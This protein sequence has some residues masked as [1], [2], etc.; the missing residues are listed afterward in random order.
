MITGLDIGLDPVFD[1][2]F[3]GQDEIRVVKEDAAVLESFA[4]L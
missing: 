1:F 4:R 3:G 2:P